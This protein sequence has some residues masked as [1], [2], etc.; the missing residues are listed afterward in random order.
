M[1]YKSANRD[2]PIYKAALE[3]SCKHLKRFFKNNSYLCK[4]HGITLR[5]QL[6]DMNNL[7]LS[8]SWY[9][10]SNL[11]SGNNKTAAL[12]YINLFSV[13]WGLDGSLLLYRDIS[14]SRI[15]K[16]VNSPMCSY[17]LKG[18]IT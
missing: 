13:Y 3:Q 15:L 1:Y 6:A 8:M 16:Y 9:T 2:T 14:K 10:I 4:L 12:V 5:T 17:P 11:K 18:S 7:G